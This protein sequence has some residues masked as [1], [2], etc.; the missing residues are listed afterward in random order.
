[1]KAS[2]VVFLVFLSLLSLCVV[3]VQ[4]VKSNVLENVVIKADGSVVGTDKI[5][6]NGNLYTVT[7]L[8]LGGIQVERSYIV[9]DGAGH[10]VRGNGTGCGVYISWYFSYG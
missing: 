9:I 3:S 10:T 7:D 2:K 6:R 5:Q 4:P 8:I 1:M